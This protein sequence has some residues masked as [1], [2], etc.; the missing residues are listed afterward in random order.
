VRELGA[1]LAEI[2]VGDRV[3]IGSSHHQVGGAPDLFELAAKQLG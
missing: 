3:A 2:L 1:V